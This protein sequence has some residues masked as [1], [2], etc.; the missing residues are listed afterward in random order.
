MEFAQDP[1]FEIASH[2][3]GDRLRWT[4]DFLSVADKAI[5]FVACVKGLEYPPDLH[6]SAQRD[7]RAWAHYL[8]DHPLVAAEFELARVSGGSSLNGR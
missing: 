6:E 4:S 3:V 5:A 1:L 7:L 8:D 2:T